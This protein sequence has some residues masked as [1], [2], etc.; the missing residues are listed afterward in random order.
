M[1][2]LGVIEM[3]FKPLRDWRE[4]ARGVRGSVLD[5]GHLLPAEAPEAKLRDLRRFIAHV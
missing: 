3:M 4:A 1:G 2:K 5:Y